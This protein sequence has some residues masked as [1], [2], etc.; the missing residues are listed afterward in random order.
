MF[1]HDLRP[2]RVMNE[3]R[4][5]RRKRLL[6]QRNRILGAGRIPKEAC[7]GPAEQARDAALHGL[8]LRAH[9]ARKTAGRHIGHFE[10]L[11]T[12]QRALGPSF[13]KRLRRD[14]QSSRYF[15]NP[16]RVCAALS[17]PVTDV[18]MWLESCKVLCGSRRMP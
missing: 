2:A 7:C 13:K 11:G 17:L 9:C 12:I 6:A 5:E 1:I 4:G 8:N 15:A 3:L 10:T 18:C 16:N 14:T